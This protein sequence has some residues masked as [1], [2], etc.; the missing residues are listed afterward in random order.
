MPLQI[1]RFGWPWLAY[2]AVGFALPASAQVIPDTTLG[3]ESSD[4]L[5][6]GI[7]V[8]GTTAD[9]VRGG[10]QRQGNLFHSFEQFSIGAGQRIYFDN[11]VGVGRIFNRVTGAQ[12]SN[13]F[14]TLG[15]NGGADL[16]LLNPNGIVFGPDARLD[17]QGSFAASTADAIE[18]GALGSYGTEG[19]GVP[20]SLL[21]VSPSAFLFGG[22]EV[23]GEIVVESVADEVGLK[24]A[25]GESLVLLGSDVTV[26][27]GRLTA[28]EGRVEVGALVGAGTVGLGTDG[29]LTFVE[30]LERGDVVFENGALV[31][32]QLADNGDIGVTARNIDVKNSA[33]LAGILGENSTAESQA[34]D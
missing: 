12:C 21:T 16:F 23:P 22:V 13:I 18:F 30:G 9:L 8:N 29:Q 6:N 11:P 19:A 1:A 4:V 31:N 27:G 17:L 24:V 34:G 3:A 26:D 5:L 2:L 15:V 28:Y 25:N 7:T 32:V 10:A 14:G 33:L 20:G